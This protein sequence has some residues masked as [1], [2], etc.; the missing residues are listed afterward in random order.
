LCLVLSTTDTRHALLAM[1][2]A[3][4]HV[5][6]RLTEAMKPAEAGRLRAAL[7]QLGPAAPGAVLA[8][9][10]VVAEKASQLNASGRFQRTWQ[11]RTPVA[12]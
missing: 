4:D 9:Q 3:G 8:S 10:R 1:S 7:T 12:V 5:I 11:Q 6:E 2:G